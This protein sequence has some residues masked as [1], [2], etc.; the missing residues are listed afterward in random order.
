MRLTTEF[1]QQYPLILRPAA[2]ALGLKYYNT[3]EPCINGHVSL[4]R[5]RNRACLDCDKAR[6]AAIYKEFY[7]AV[8][9]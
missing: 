9:S 5:V 3:G 6:Q 2:K 1:K 4:R 8:K 7:V